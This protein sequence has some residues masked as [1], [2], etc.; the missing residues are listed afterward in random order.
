MTSIV[1]A[2]LA[3]V[4]SVLALSSCTQTK[5]FSQSP[6]FENGASVD[7]A[8]LEQREKRHYKDPN[9]PPKRC[10]AL[11]GG[12]VRSA[13]FSMGV[14]Q[15]LQRVKD[16][17]GKSWLENT[18]II[19]AV[20]GGS[21]TASWFYAQHYLGGNP[22]QNQKESNQTPVTNS[23]L[24]LANHVGSP[25]F[26][27]QKD[28]RILTT[29][30]I[31]V[32]LPVHFAFSFPAHV[33]LNGVFG[34]HSNV[35]WVHEFYK[36][37]LQEKFHNDQPIAMADLRK[38]LNDR[39][40]AEQRLPYFVI[41]TTAG[42]DSFDDQ[43]KAPL[44]KAVFEFTPEYY[45]SKAFH[46]GTYDNTFSSRIDLAR[47]V[48]TS[49]A[50]WDSLNLWEKGLL[51]TLVSATALDLGIDVRNPNPQDGAR[52]PVGFMPLGLYTLPPGTRPSYWASGKH[53]Y[54]IHLSDGGHSDNLG[55]YSLAMRE[56]ENII[57]VDG[58]HDR[59][60]DFDDYHRLKI[61][62]RAPEINADIIVPA[63]DER[64]AGR[65]EPICDAGDGK[66][67]ERTAK[68][69][70]DARL[71]DEQKKIL[72]DERAK[73]TERSENHYFDNGSIK[74]SN[75]KK[76]NLTYIK[77][78]IREST[79]PLRTD[80]AKDL[81]A[82]FIKLDTTYGAGV[83]QFLQNSF[84]SGE[85]PDGGLSAARE[86]FEATDCMFPHRPT[87]DQD[88]LPEQFGAYRDLGCMITAN[89][90]ADT[91]LPRKGNE[92]LSYEYHLVSQKNPE[93]GKDEIVHHKCSSP[94][95]S[96]EEARR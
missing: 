86:F 90:L 46:I 73:F 36:G 17:D 13:A 77:M 72:A 1:K 70:E 84:L 48:A 85:C 95:T 12:G 88:Y 64:I 25:Q 53:A 18:D 74:L 75:G 67:S 87:W 66:A 26:A 37:R 57:V 22:N 94:P 10:I 47:V 51:R 2:T 30:D 21:Y 29:W 52:W 41:N 34:F 62:L 20:S 40:I 82:K 76:L 8:E 96:H 81:G 9:A 79:R 65:P 27:I 5:D 93:T 59:N 68:R 7:F 69:N 71:T 31:P 43:Q 24:L 16:P 91:L 38:F 6:A 54:R 39:R 56:C 63:I 23:H 83:A 61:C 44:N 60:Y 89:Y 78:G 3:V 4:A 14:L 58:A 15:A 33:L 55:I 45:G 32:V 11:S 49:G 50:A 19:S 42:D 80:K 35:S 92:K 28:V